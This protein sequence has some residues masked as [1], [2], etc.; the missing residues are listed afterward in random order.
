MSSTVLVIDGNGKRGIFAYYMS[1]CLQASG[2]RP[3]LIVGV[4]SGALVGA[5]L[6]SGKVGH[7]PESQM[8]QL[9]E[10]IRT[11]GE[12]RIPWWTAMV[13]GPQKTNLIRS[14]FK[15]MLLKDVEI[16]LHILVDGVGDIPR[17]FSSTDKVDGEIELYRILDATTAIPAVFP[18]VEIAGK[19]YVDALLIATSPKTIA[20]FVALTAF[21]TS[22]F[23][24]I[25]IGARLEE[26]LSPTQ[27]DSLHMKCDGILDHFRHG[28]VSKMISRRDALM[29]TLVRKSLKDRFLRLEA[30]ID[31]GNRASFQ[32]IHDHCKEKAKNACVDYE[33]FK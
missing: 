8:I 28:L 9:G 6:A 20:Y 19:H 25:S 31:I 1:E 2:F 33:S 12:R 7:I 11:T 5:L 32:S 29:E 16:P 18:S 10:T 27:S 17:I 3:D 21:G 15:D 30:I 4:S 24:M 26:S 13:P 22:D 14:I 23:R